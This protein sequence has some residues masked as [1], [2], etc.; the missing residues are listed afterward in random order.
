VQRTAIFVAKIDKIK[1][2]GAAHRNIKFNI[3][4]RCTFKTWIYHHC[5]KYFG[6]LHLE[7][8]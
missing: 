1:V 3:A 6:A 4:V 8:L 2:E 5:Y 7:F